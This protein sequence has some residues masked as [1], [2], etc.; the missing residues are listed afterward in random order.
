MVKKG[1]EYIESR[2]KWDKKGQRKGIRKT[3]EQ[4]YSLKVSYA[5]WH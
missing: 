2:R 5:N 4:M 3:D 1:K